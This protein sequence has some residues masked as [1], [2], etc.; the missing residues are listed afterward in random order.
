MLWLLK[1][2]Y[3]KLTVKKILKVKIISEFEKFQMFKNIKRAKHR[4]NWWE[5]KQTN[6][7]LTKIRQAP[8]FWNQ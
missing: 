7:K 2:L 1:V 4:G 6:K 8:K 5:Y 3:A